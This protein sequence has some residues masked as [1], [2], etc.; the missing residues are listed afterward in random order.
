MKL[1]YSTIVL[2]MF[3]CGATAYGASSEVTIKLLQ[4]SDVHGNYFPTNFITRQ[5]AKGS[6]ARVYSAVKEMRR[7][8]DG[9]VILLDNG[10]FLQGQP[11]AYYYNYM[12]T[13]APHVGADVLNYM[14]YDA[15]NV[16]NHDVETGR[17]VLDRWSSQCDM[18]ILG[19]NIIDTEADIPHFRPYTVVEHDGV[20]V[21]VLG[22]ITPAIPAWLPESLWKG[23]RFDDMEATARKWIPIIKVREN[24]DVIVGMFHSGQAAY[25]LAGTRENASLEVAR[26]VPGFDVVLMGHDH[27]RENMKVV[28]VEGDTVLVMN[29]ANN[30]VMLTDITMTF[31]LDDNGKVV[32]KHFDGKL[33]PTD[34]Y[35]PDPEFMKEFEPQIATITEFV[36]GPIGTMDESITTRDAYFGPSKFVDLIHELQLGLT[37]ADISFAA[38]LSYDATIDKGQIMMSDMFNLYKYENMLYVME[39]TGQEIKDYLEYAYSIWTNQMKSANDHLLLFKDVATEGDESRSTLRYPS[40]NFDSAA[41]IIYEVDVTKPA[42]EKV[43]IKSMADGS[44]FDL[45]KTYR[46]ALNSYRGNGG[47]ELLTKGAGIPQEELSG[48]IVYSTDRDLRYYLTDYIK[49][50]GTLKPHRLNQWKFVPEKWAD[51]AAKRD[52]AIL[53]P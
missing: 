33:T 18:P 35:E 38:P 50:L 36:N 25:D 16:G 2:S 11:T 21:A 5:P 32:N 9:N 4:T 53:F 40:Y 41:G 31:E 17:E 28:N 46:V 3:A 8:Y 6:L 39:L 14:G 48:R 15:G 34:S 42:G 52:R 45:G 43:T 23:L 13:E 24:P 26:N 47:G 30:G 1:L 10:D 51:K 7:D 19:A 49:R 37:D 44:A 22:M 12:D 20:K 27:R 29:P